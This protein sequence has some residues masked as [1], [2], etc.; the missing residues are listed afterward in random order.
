MSAPMERLRRFGPGAIRTPANVITTLRLVLAI[1]AL[2]LIVDLG[3]TWVT[4]GL[5]FVLSVTDGL[6]G[7]IARR[8]GTTR[9]GA[10]LDPLADKFLAV[11]G[12][13]A[14]AIRGDI[15]WIPVIVIAGREVLISIY[16][17]IEGRKGISLPA[18]QLGKWKTFIQMSAIGFV[19]LP[20]TA[21]LRWLWLTAIWAAVLLTVISGI[22]VIVAA[23]RQTA[24]EN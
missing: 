6:D 18:R 9:A 21:D 14:L 11:G 12:F 5:W 4:V 1:P 19:L 10:F 7:W 17:S 24:G 20:L 13:S 2:F 23:R 22:D 3:S 8:D 15:S 16:R